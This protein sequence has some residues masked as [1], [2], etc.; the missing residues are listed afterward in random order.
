MLLICAFASADDLELIKRLAGLPDS[1]LDAV[2]SELS[3][4]LQ[5]S[6]LFFY[7]LEGSQ[8]T[9]LLFP[10]IVQFGRNLAISVNGH[11]GSPSQ[12][13]AF[14]IDPVT[15]E[16]EPF[17][18]EQTPSGLRPVHTNDCTECHGQPLRLRWKSRLWG[19]MYSPG[20]ELSDATHCVAAR[21]II[22]F[23]IT[24]WR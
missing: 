8:P 7:N 13:K 1:S 3:P 23:S 5:G 17:V 20:V 12:L 21:F 18:F 4:R 9:S 10:R 19:G 14:N 11:P 16:L 15:G 6:T 22:P 2:L 24:E